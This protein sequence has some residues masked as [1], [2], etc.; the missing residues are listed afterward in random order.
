M[1]PKSDHLA[2]TAF[3]KKPPAQARCGDGHLHVGAEECD[4]GVA[5]DDG[6]NCT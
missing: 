3:D 6:A 1:V 5:N 2:N 4:A